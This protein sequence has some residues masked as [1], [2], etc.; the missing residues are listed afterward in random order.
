MWFLM[1]KCTASIERWLIM[2][3]FCNCASYTGTYFIYFMTFT[4]TYQLIKALSLTKSGMQTSP[5]TI[6]QQVYRSVVFTEVLLITKTNKPL[7]KI[8]A[9][10][11]YLSMVLCF[12]ISLAP[13]LLPDFTAKRQLVNPWTGSWYQPE[14]QARLINLID[15]Q[16]LESKLFEQLCL[17]DHISLPK[18]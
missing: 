17:S 3:Y 10:A 1:C 8:Q 4:R 11:D 14:R 5:L 16:W 7:L 9:H 6:N 15:L 18:S 2:H 12:S 13:P